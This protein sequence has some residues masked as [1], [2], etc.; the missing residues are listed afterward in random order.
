MFNVPSVGA[1]L[2]K[3]HFFLLLLGYSRYNLMLLTTKST[4]FQT[5]KAVAVLQPAA[6]VVA[7]HI[8]YISALEIRNIY[9]SCGKVAVSPCNK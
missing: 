4:Q 3:E 5:S 8:I 6:Q 7:S 1:E 9:L 2:H